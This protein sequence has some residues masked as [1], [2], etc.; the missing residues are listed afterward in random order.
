[1][2]IVPA[3][4]LISL[5]QTDDAGQEAPGRLPVFLWKVLLVQMMPPVPKRQALSVPTSAYIV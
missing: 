3:Q 2:V 1:M 5:C 4:L